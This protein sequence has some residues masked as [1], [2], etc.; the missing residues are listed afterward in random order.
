MAINVAFSLGLGLLLGVI[1]VFVRDVGQVMAVVLQLWFW[2]TPIVYMPSIL[3]SGFGRVIAA[4]PLYYIVSSFQ[5]VLLYGQPPALVPLA[6][7]ALGSAFLLAIA[8]L[9]FRR[10]APEMVDVL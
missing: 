9:M 10:A 8:F 2:V 4:N 3:P 6:W 1:N 7:T 5:N